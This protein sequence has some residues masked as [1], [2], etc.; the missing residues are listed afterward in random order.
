MLTDNRRAVNVTMVSIVVDVGMIVLH[1]RML[2][3]VTVPLGDV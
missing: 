3:A 1:R 2:M